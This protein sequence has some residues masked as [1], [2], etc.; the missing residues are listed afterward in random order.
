[1]DEQTQP[2]EQPTIEATALPGEN[3]DGLREQARKLHEEAGAR[4]SAAAELRTAAAALRE[5]AAALVAP[6][7]AGKPVESRAE[8]LT[9]IED[10]APRRRWLRRRG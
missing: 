7:D 9:A 10:R 1:M 8:D 6:A 4:A 5:E 3:P 2:D